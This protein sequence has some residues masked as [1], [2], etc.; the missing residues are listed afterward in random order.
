MGALHSMR[1]AGVAALRDGRLLL[2][3]FGH[4]ILQLKSGVFS[5]EILVH[6]EQFPGWT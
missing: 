1:H 5:V 6:A 3:E 4:P 2:D